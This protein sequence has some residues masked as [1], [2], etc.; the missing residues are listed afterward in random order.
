MWTLLVLYDG[1]GA[2]CHCLTAP[3]CE[4]IG[5]SHGVLQLY[6]QTREYQS[7][8][9]CA[10]SSQQHVIVPPTIT[11]SSFAHFARSATSPTRVIR[12]RTALCAELLL[13]DCVRFSCCSPQDCRSIRFNCCSPF[14]SA[15]AAA[16]RLRSLQLLL[17]D[18]NCSPPP[19]PP[20]C[21]HF[22]CCSLPTVLEDS[23][24]CS[25]A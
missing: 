1:A 12:R 23:S 5:L 21:V 18:F 14:A 16:P 17:P 13:P 3:R 20:D 24:P 9:Y 22:D 6:R 10:I 4:V 19:P 15:S 2:S 11:T 25:S 8:L 7:V